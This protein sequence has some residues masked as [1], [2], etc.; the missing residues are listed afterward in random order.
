MKEK[1]IVTDQKKLDAKIFSMKRGGA[2]SL[3]ILSDF[4]RTLTKAYVNGKHILSILGILIEKNYLSTEYSLQAKALVKKYFPIEQNIAMPLAEKK[5][6]MLEWWTKIF[7][8][9]I[10]Y[11]LNKNDIVKAA[12]SPEIQL[13]Q[14]GK[15]FFHLLDTHKIP[16]VIMSATGTGEDGIG[17]FLSQQ[18]VLTDNIYLISNRFIWDAN[19]RAI[20]IRQPIIHAL[21]KDETIIQ[22]FPAFKEVQKRKNVILLGDTLD[23]VGMVVGFE[24]D[25]LISV[26]WLNEDTEKH[27][28][29][30][31]QVFD[32]VITDD[33]SMDA[34]N[35]LVSSIV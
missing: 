20:S 2:D 16:L 18:N 10:A 21:N 34:V 8:L 19:D 9:L 24:Y 27:L 1:I 13:R 14:N 23:D 15:N 11:G 30:Y 33:G 4:D 31:Q 5:P 12:A 28:A 3:H 32:I 25:Q 29:E 35:T 22:N 6:L 7:D 26:G 17:I